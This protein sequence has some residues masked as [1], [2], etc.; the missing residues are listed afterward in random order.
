M[1][2]GSTI[3]ARAFYISGHFF[4]KQKCE[5]AKLTFCGE[6]EYGTVKFSSLADLECYPY[7]LS[8]GY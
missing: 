7:P 3:S 5:M 1:T 6:L 4:A 2:I 8:S